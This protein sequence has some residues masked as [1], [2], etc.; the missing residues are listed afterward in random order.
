[1]KL[2]ATFA[3]LAAFFT[4]LASAGVLEARE[5][6]NCGGVYC[7]VSLLNKGNYREHIK[8]VLSQKH[9][10]QDEVHINYSL[11]NCLSGGEIMFIEYCSRGCGGTTTIDPDYCL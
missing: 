8:Q 10:P 7:G 3:I 2:T 11:F 5:S 1:M 4:T 9:Q 6:C